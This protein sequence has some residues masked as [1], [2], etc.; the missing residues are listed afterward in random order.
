M[1]AFV[2]TMVFLIVVMMAITVTAVSGQA[3]YDDSTDPEEVLSMLAATEVR[4]SDLTNIEDDSL[5]YLPDVIAYSIT[6]DSMV[7]GYLDELMG[8]VFGKHRFCLT[9]SYQEKSMVVGEELQYYRY[10]SSMELPVTIGGRLHLV[11]G[12]I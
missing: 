2:D 5:V 6:N 9:C 11:L 8:S 3:G 7:P 10:Q 12:T 4:L 1:T